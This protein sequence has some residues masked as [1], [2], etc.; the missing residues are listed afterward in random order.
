MREL[1]E[2]V[3]DKLGVMA[4]RNELDGRK[5]LLTTQL[6]DPEVGARQAGLISLLREDVKLDMIAIL[7]PLVTDAYANNTDTTVK[8]CAL[9]NAN[10]MLELLG[11]H[12]LKGDQG[13]FKAVA[14]LLSHAKSSVRANALT[15]LGQIVEPGDEEAIQAV[16]NVLND[17]F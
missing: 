12:A 9:K 3:K 16:N 2:L 8:D 6:K 13:A 17:Q 5:A 11:Q 7:V 10:K 15:T 4:R 1:P 14:E